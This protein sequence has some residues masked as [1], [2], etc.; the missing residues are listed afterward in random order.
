MTNPLISVESATPTNHRI[1]F[2]LA[3]AQFLFDRGGFWQL[4]EYEECSFEPYRRIV[5][6]ILKEEEDDEG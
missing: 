5:G 6:K 1:F 2:E 4:R 3:M